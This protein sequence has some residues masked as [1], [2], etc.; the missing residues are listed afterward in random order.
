[1]PYT[2]SCTPAPLTFTIRPRFDWQFLVG[3]AWG[4]FLAYQMLSVG[5]RYLRSANVSDIAIAVVTSVVVLVSL[6]RRERI[7]IYP[8]HMVWRKNYFG[9]TRLKAA[10]LAEILGADWTEGEQRGRR[11]KAPDYVEFY[12]TSGSVKACFGFN[13]ED[14]DRMREDIRRMYPGFVNGWARSSVRSKSLTLL[15]L[16]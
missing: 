16:H 8:D 12:L 3:I 13:F 1:M 7:E 14:F 9:I 11:G 4:C 6:I 2:V 15:N 5:W 10:P